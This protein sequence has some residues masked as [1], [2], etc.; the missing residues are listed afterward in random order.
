MEKFGNLFFTDLEG[1][2]LWRLKDSDTEI[3]AKDY[4]PNVHVILEDSSHLVCDSTCG[5]VSQ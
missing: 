5:W 4:T 1:G 2:S 3:L